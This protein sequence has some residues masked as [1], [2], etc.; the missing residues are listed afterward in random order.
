MRNE[1]PNG[2]AFEIGLCGDVRRNCIR[3]GGHRR[4]AIL[5]GVNFSN[6]RPRTLGSLGLILRKNEHHP[7]R[8]QIDG[9]N[10]TN[11]TNVIDFAGLFSEPQLAFRAASTLDCSFGSNPMQQEPA[12]ERHG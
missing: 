4:Q 7:V 2:N 8:F 11:E 6:Y 3:S 10:L 1:Y 9:T 5:N 12:L